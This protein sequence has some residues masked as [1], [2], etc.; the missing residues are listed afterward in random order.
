MEEAH[1]FPVVVSAF[2]PD[3]QGTLVVGTSGGQ[4]TLVPEQ[5]AEV[6][7][8]ESGGGVVWTQRLLADG[9]STLSVGASAGQ[10]ADRAQVVVDRRGQLPRLGAAARRGS[11]L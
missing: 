8:A 3:D 9:Q 2:L 10:I 7:E 4:I 6:V 1:P 5:G 11:I